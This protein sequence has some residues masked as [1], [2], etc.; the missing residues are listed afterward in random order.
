MEKQQSAI[1]EVTKQTNLYLTSLNNIYDCYLKTLKTFE[2]ASGVLATAKEANQLYEDITTIVDLYNKYGMTVTALG[3]Y[4]FDLY[5]TRMQQAAYRRAM[6]SYY[7]EA[8]V[9]MQETSTIPTLKMNYEES[10]DYI[11]LIAEEARSLMFGIRNTIS[12]YTDII[13]INYRNEKLLQ[14]DL[15]TWTDPNE[16]HYTVTYKDIQ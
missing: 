4:D 9:I 10:L 6:Y 11:R 15:Q 12:R 2:A 14:W 16:Y 8:L 7:H 1:E 5:L 3:P 13:A